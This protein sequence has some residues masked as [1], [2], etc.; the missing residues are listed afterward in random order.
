MTK[1]LTG[2]SDPRA[3]R[4]ADQSRQRVDSASMADCAIRALRMYHAGNPSDV[5]ARAIRW[6]ERGR[7]SSEDIAREALR[8]AR[9]YDAKAFQDLVDDRGP[10]LTELATAGVPWQV[11]VKAERQ[12]V[13]RAGSDVSPSLYPERAG[14]PITKEDVAEC[15]DLHLHR[16]AGRALTVAVVNTHFGYPPPQTEKA[17]G[18]EKTGQIGLGL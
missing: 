18:R 2:R 17:G 3:Q 10:F 15:F 4:K 9:F 1:L 14:E 16:D 13:W 12:R 8:V 6:P 5:I 7:M 11:F